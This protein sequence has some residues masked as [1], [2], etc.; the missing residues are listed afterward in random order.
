MITRNISQTLFPNKQF[1]THLTSGDDE[2]IHTHEYFEIVYIINGQITH[3]CNNETM[4]F[5]KGHM[6]LLRPGDIHTYKRDKDECVHRDIMIDSNL[7]KKICDFLRIGIYEEIIENKQ[8]LYCNVSDFQIDYFENQLGYIC[9]STDQNYA[10]PLSD[11]LLLI[12]STLSTIL[13]SFYIHQNLIDQ[14]AYPAWLK[15][16]LRRFTNLGYIQGGID[17]LM[18]NISYDQSYV[19]RVFK[20]YTGQT[21]TEYLNK[22][23]LNCA[24]T[25]LSHTN[26]SIA[27]IVEEIGLSNYSYFVKLF[28]KNYGLTPIQYRLQTKKRN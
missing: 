18:E 14:T 1:S 24:R 11:A 10:S 20:K 9:N 13:S 28:K 2:H 21:I 12:N 26:M 25:F 17:K 7:F 6:V 3:I 8:C 27:N 15:E 4:V 22:M 16:F 5:Q 23:R 19:C